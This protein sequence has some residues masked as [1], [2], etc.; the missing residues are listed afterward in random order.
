[1]CVRR[2]M[3]VL[4]LAAGLVLFGATAFVWA[5]DVDGDGV[6]DAIDI[7]NNTPAG[8][9]VDAKG[10]PDVP[11]GTG[12]DAHASARER[13]ADVAAIFDFGSRDTN[14][15]RCELSASIR[16]RLSRAARVDV[17]PTGR[18][19]QASGRRLSQRQRC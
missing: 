14:V 19:S 1:M 3:V 6:D 2:P 5:G 10:R 12:K 9:A 11:R 18:C 8:A 13:L 7:C 16:M 4:A 15:L 17:G